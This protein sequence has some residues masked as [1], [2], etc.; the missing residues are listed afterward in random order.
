M[1]TSSNSAMLNDVIGFQT[2]DD[3]DVEDEEEEDEEADPPKKR[4]IDT[5]PVSVQIEG[6]DL[7]EESTGKSLVRRK[8]AKN[9]K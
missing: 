3:T 9:L 2:D 4:K 8:K 6:V 5:E 7:S 1:H